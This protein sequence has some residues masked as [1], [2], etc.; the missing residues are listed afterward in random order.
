MGVAAEAGRGND[1][2]TLRVSLVAAPDAPLW[3]H[4]T[5]SLATFG[6]I[7]VAHWCFP[8]SDGTGERRLTVLGA[9]PYLRVRDARVERWF[10]DFG[11]GLNT[12]SDLYDARGRRFS[13]RFQ[14][15]D[16]LAFGRSFGDAAAFELSYRFIHYSNAGIR[17]PNPGVNFHVLRL[18]YRSRR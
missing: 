10:F 14:F 2:D 18:E 9:T 3:L 16:H 8:P 15:S 4:G 11:I 6:E 1:T 5:L 7:A 17:R 13:T 12:L